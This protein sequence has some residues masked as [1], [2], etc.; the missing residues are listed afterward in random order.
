MSVLTFCRL[1]DP[2]G[3]PL[4]T[5][6]DYT[7]LDYVLNCT[8]GAVGVL[9]LT[10]DTSFDPSLLRRDGRIGV[11]RSLNGQPPYLDNNAIYLIETVTFRSGSTFVRAYHA[12]G[13][14][15][16]RIVAYYA[17]S[18]YADKSAAPADDQIKA[19]W[20]E[21]AGALIAAA[22]RDGVDTQADISA[23]VST[24][25]DLSAG[26]SIAKAAARRVLLDVARELS[27]ASETAGTYLTFE[28]IAPTETTLELRTYTGQRGI[29]HTADS[30]NPV[31][32]SEARG[33]L[34]NAALTIDWH[35]EATFTDAGGAGEKIDRKIQTAFDATRAAVSPFGRIE[36]FVDMSNIDT[37]A[38]LADEADAALEAA[39]PWT[40]FTGDLIETPATTRGVQFDLGDI[41]TVEDPRSG[42]Q[43]DCRLDV[44]HE[45]IGGGVRRVQVVLRSVA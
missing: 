4:A 19:F 3:G 15:S 17:G 36:R 2:F 24:Q 29:D 33:N 44:I 30:G 42:Q 40:V 28:I 26:A 25:A 18:A 7:Q 11:W 32:L 5:I 14:M 6:A 43:F 37:D 8:P 41:V 23:Y 39:R 31:I 45:T 16:R 20:R 21:N 35:D 34:E 9:E 22:T 13:L 38:A 1:A 27:E 12:T 10:L